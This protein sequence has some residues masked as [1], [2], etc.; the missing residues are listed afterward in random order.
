MVSTLSPASGPVGTQVVITGSNFSAAK[1]HV[2]FGL[3]YITNLAS[4]DGTSLRFVV[5]DALNVCPPDLTDPC[6]TLM[7]RVA[8]G[9]YPV[10]V[11]VGSATSNSVN[12]TVSEE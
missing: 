9:S 1:N 2:K 5:P 3:G 12:F 6:P 4:P 11:I 10:A 7:P 8:Q